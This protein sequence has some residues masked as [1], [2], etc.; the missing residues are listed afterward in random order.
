MEAALRVFETQKTYN[1]SQSCHNSL[2][3]SLSV[4][5]ASTCHLVNEEQVTPTAAKR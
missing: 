4:S 2:I 3:A 5:V 1:L